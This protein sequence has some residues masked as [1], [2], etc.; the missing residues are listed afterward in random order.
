M[1]AVLKQ[2]KEKDNQYLV[3]P[4]RNCCIWSTVNRR[5]G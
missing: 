3:P 1:P 4:S 2:K 5:E